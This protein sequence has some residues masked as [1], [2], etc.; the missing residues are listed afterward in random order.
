M[1]GTLKRQIVA[2]MNA[3]QLRGV[4]RELDIRLDDY[5]RRDSL[6]SGI[7]R[8]RRATANVL[9]AHLTPGALK[10][11]CEDRGVDAAGSRESQ[12][13]MLLRRPTASRGSAEEGAN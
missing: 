12:M 4:A 1:A 6:E 10:R 9:L 7:R 8:A 11:L 5:R 2:C 13:A 3:N